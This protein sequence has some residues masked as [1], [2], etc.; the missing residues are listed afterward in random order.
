MHAT[1]PT[2]ADRLDSMD[3][4]I[5]VTRARI[6]VLGFALAL[7]LFASST[8]LSIG[9]AYRFSAVWVFLPSFVALSLGF[10]L[11]LVAMLLFVNALRLDSGGA[12]RIWPFSFGELLMYLALSQ[13]LA[14]GIQYLATG[15][16]FVF[17]NVPQR[18]GLDPEQIE[19][20][21]PLA[22]QLT[23][24]L[25]LCAGMGWLATMYAAPVYF[26]IRN[27]LPWNRKWLLAVTYLV[28]LIVVSWISAIPYQLH[29]RAAGKQE[30]LAAHFAG[31]FAQPLLWVGEKPLFSAAT[32]Q[33]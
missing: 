27:P 14:G 22:E 12:G 8:L 1:Q 3:V 29:A 26:V 32:E 9:Q 31:Q 20:L 11:T 13:V 18:T 16:M 23:F 6:T 7:C 21:M 17:H 28:L 10:S 5:N 24:W 33:R 19:L 15:L 4:P 25:T 2:P 30:N